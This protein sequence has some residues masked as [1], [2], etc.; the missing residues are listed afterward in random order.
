VEEAGWTIDGT[1]QAL[2]PLRGPGVGRP[3]GAVNLER[4]DTGFLVIA[5]GSS[6]RLKA[7][8]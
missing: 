7:I 3:D 4:L 1:N 5:A 2:A 8:V 6:A